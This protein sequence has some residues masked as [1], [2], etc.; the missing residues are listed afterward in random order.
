MAWQGIAGEARLVMFWQDA[1]G[2]ASLGKAG[3]G[4]VSFGTAGKFCEHLIGENNGLPRR[5]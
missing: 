5:L 3:Y 4:V 2:Q 1:S